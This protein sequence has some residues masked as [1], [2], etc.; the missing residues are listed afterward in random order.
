MEFDWASRE[1]GGTDWARMPLDSRNLADMPGGTMEV[2][3]VPICPST[4]MVTSSELRA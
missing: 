3:L 4:P 2:G 1:S